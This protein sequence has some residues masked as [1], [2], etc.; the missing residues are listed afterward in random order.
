LDLAGGGVG[1]GD[2]LLL[3]FSGEIPFP[4]SCYTIT[5]EELVRE[6]TT[7]RVLHVAVKKLSQ[8]LDMHEK[9][10]NQEVAC[11]MRVRHKNIVRF[12]G[13]CADTQGKMWNHEGKVIMADIRQRLLCFEF[14][15]NGSL[16]MHVTGMFIYL[17]Y[18]GNSMNTEY[19]GYFCIS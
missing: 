12:L 7:S 8:T 16:D 3:V 17:M 5:I 15:P 1:G 4:V 10:F 11:L 19:A 2:E 13:Y 18:I 6:S 14:M 9:K